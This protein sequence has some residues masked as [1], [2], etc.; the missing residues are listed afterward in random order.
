[1]VATSGIDNGVEQ[2]RR[3]AQG[4]DTLYGDPDINT[5]IGNGGPDTLNR[6]GR[7]G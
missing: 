6:A 7:R 5:L 3:Q 2:V 4:G 1:L